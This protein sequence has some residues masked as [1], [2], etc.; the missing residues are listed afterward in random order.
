MEKEQG[1][2]FRYIL[3][4]NAVARRRLLNLVR[5]RK[6]NK[7]RWRNITKRDVYQLYQRAE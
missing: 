1:H 3:K 7:W 5:K 6:K 4:L 2:V